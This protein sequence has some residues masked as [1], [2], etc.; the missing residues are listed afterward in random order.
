ME[1]GGK[2]KSR[3]NARS[4]EVRS[5]KARSFKAR[6][7]DASLSNARLS[8]APVSIAANNSKSA[9]ISGALLASLD[10]KS[11][12]SSSGLAT[13]SQSKSQFALSS[14]SSDSS[15]SS[16][17]AMDSALFSADNCCNA[18]VISSSSGYRGV[19]LAIGSSK[20]SSKG[21]KSKRN[22]S[23]VFNRVSSPRLISPISGI[24]PNSVSSKGFAHPKRSRESIAVSSGAC[25]V[26]SIFNNSSTLSAWAETASSSAKSKVISSRSADKS[27]SPNNHSPLLSSGEEGLDGSSKVTSSGFA[28]GFQKGGLFPSNKSANVLKSSTPMTEPVEWVGS[29]FKDSRTGT[30]GKETSGGSGRSL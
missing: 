1:T 22:P 18:E 12:T 16:G 15:G 21:G 27:S 10:E 24:S 23:S 3:S 20:D 28:L 17:S 6:S 9:G 7:F 5:S 29:G 2:S 25:R 11:K 13:S 26:S 8:V 14:D 4:F 19:V 30:G